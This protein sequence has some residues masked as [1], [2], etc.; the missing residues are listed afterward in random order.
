MNATTSR[1]IDTT[2]FSVPDLIMGSASVVLVNATTAG[3]E[4]LV[5]VAAP[6]TH[7]KLQM[8]KSAR[9]MDNVVAVDA[10]VRSKKISDI[11]ANTVRNAQRVQVVV[12]S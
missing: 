8:V 1:V 12:T 7:V 5:N 9:V 4:T 10:S 11:Q 6:S 3:E 2:Q